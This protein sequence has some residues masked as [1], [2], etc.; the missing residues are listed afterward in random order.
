MA[1][2]ALEMEIASAEDARAM[3]VLCLIPINLNLVW[4]YGREVFG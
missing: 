3:L 1:W 4:I 2:F